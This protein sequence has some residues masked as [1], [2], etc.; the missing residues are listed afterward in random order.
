MTE[1]FLPEGAGPCVKASVIATLITKEGERFESSNYCMNPQKICPRV[2]A[3]YA[4]GQGYQLC[5]DIC[6]QPAHAEVNVLAFVESRGHNMQDAT[7]YVDYTD[8]TGKVSPWVCEPCAMLCSERG[9]SHILGKPPEEFLTHAARQWGAYQESRKAV[10][11][12]K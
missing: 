9:A 7:V 1:V 6:Q 2:V 11:G 5:K 4:P 8:N 10:L 12:E 3:G